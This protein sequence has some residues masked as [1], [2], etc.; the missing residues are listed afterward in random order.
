VVRVEKQHLELMPLGAQRAEHR[1]RRRQEFALARVDPHRHLVARLRRDQLGELPHERQRQV[2]DAKIARVLERLQRRRL[3]GARH[4]GDDDDAHRPRRRHGRYSTSSTRTCGM[5][6]LASMSARFK[7]SWNSR[8]ECL[9]WYLS[10]WLRAATSLIEVMFRPGRMGTR[11]IGT[12]TSRIEWRSSS[13]PSRSYSS[14]SFHSTSSTT[15]SIF[16]ASRTAEI[17][18]R[19]LMLMMPRPRISMWCLMISEPPP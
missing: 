13:T 15:N 8:A 16:L 18:N 19:S 1:A 12:A 10:S 4:A 6:G 2:V 7:R 9:P 17:P 5:S 11:S 14:S 3:A